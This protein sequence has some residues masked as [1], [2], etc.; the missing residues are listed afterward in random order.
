VRSVGGQAEAAAIFLWRRRRRAAEPGVEA[1][2]AGDQ[3]ALGG[4]AVQ[5]DRVFSLSVIPDADEVG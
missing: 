3:G 2:R 4:N 1:R 5:A